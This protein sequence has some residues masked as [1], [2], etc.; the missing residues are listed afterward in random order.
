MR[1]EELEAVEEDQ[2]LAGSF[3]GRWTM[4][5]PRTVRR[6]LVPPDERLL[7]LLGHHTAAGRPSPE[8][9]ACPPTTA[10]LNVGCSSDV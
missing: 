4:Q 2:Q 1:R 10:P 3:G 7:P 9:M 8:H 5:G 6:C